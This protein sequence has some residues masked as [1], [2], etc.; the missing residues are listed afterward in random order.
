MASGMLMAVV[1]VGSYLNAWKVLPIVL[2]LLV[3]ARLL[4]W[5]DKDAPRAHLPREVINIALLGAMIA[6]FFLFLF[7]PNFFIALPVFLLMFLGSVGAYVLIRG[8]KVGLKDLKAELRGAFT[9]GSGGPKQVKVSV[10]DV[11]LMNAKGEPVTPPDNEAPERVAYEGVQQLLRRPVRHGAELITVTPAESHASVRY[12]V[13]G[14]V[15]GGGELERTLMAS[16]IGY[17]KQL[18]GMDVNERRKPQTG[19]MRVAGFGRKTEF[20]VQTS[21]SATGESLKMHADPKKRFTL[22][23]Q[24]LGFAPDQLEMMKQLVTEKTGVVLVSTPSGQGLTTLLYGVIRAHDA[25]L[26]HIHT[27]ERAP[28]TDMEGITQNKL[29]PTATGAEEFKSVDWVV[30]QEPDILLLPKVEDPRTAATLI[31]FADERR[32]YIGMHSSSTFD[33]ISMWRKL[34]GDDKLAMKNLKLVVTGTLIRKLCSACKAGYTPDPV[35]LRKLNMDPDK[36]GKL[37]QARSMPMKDAKGN[38][39]TCPYCHELYYR[40]RT[41]IFE[42][43]VIDEDVRNVVQSGGT[44][45]QLKAVFRKQRSRYLQEQALALVEAGETSVQEVLRVIKGVTDAAPAPAPGAP[46]V[47]KRPAPPRPAPPSPAGAARPATPTRPAPPRKPSA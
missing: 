45:V 25:F 23:M 33:T 6:G 7:V 35:T 28:E 22:D 16:A 20:E 39:V 17:L 42:T 36:V 19:K 40:G 1:E 5:V 14:F 46:A 31:K 9:R 2:L 11:L 30:S 13:D 27:V 34:V 38:D 32:V 26:N 12:S 47:P 3:W 43:F 18:S 29:A 41:G 10:D 44:T 21:G 24:Q 8:Q 15:Y 37:Y 4:T